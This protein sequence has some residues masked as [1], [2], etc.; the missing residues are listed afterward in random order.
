VTVNGVGIAPLQKGTSL[1]LPLPGGAGVRRVRLR[2]VFA[3]GAEP[4]TQPRMERPR[5]DG[6]PDSPALWTVHLPAGY[7]LGTPEAEA[8]GTARPASAAGLDLARAE[9][10]LR[11]SAVLAERPRSRGELDQLLAAQQRFHLYCRY[12]AHELALTGQGG[13]ARLGPRGQ[14]LA[15]WLEELQE[16]NLQLSRTHSFEAVQEEARRQVAAGKMSGA[17]ARLPADGAGE[18]AVSLTMSSAEP[19]ADALP[20]RGLPLFWQGGA[21]EEMPV[22]HL[23]TPQSQHFRRSVA[24][25]LLVL[26]LLLVA[27]LLSRSPGVLGWVRALWPEQM[28]LLGGLAWQTLGPNLLVVFLIALGVCGRVAALLWWS[29][30]L[31]RR[32]VGGEVVR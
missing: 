5:L 25:S 7:S 30:A 22:L 11:L 18:V 17:L 15:D 26:L 1:W 28:V 29:P 32:R 3:E 8:E 19:H 13:S 23:T 16:S 24:G 10:Q 6:V 20:E 31:F 14:P 4:L 12:A 21:G 27:W 2:W 9:A